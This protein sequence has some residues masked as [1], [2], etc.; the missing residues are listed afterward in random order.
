MT[1]A[2]ANHSRRGECS[3][4]RS[5]SSVARIDVRLLPPTGEPPTVRRAPSTA[6][7]AGL[8]LNAVRQLRRQ[9]I[10]QQQLVL[11]GPAAH[12]KGSLFQ[13]AQHH[14][15]ESVPLVDDAC[16]WRRGVGV[17]VTTARSFKGL[18]ADIVIA[19]SLSGFGPLFTPT[20]LYVAWTRARHRLILV[21]QSGGAHG[22]RGAWR[23]PGVQSS[24][25]SQRQP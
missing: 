7:D 9:G 10:K 11:I 13:L 15:V 5:S 6:A 19:Y 4:A 24:T 18:E 16:D 2:I 20:D 14:E 17:L 21:C 12:P 8:V 22:C 25:T 1:K 3:I 23:N